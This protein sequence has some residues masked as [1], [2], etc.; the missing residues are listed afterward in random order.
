MMDWLE[1]KKTYIGIFI[2]LIGT[3]GNAVGVPGL[4]GIASAAVN[5][6]GAA[7]AAYGRYKARP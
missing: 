5:V 1:G 2:T 4:D 7:I 3:L 6:V